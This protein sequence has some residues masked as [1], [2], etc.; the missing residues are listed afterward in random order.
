MLNLL[1]S[2]KWSLNQAL[3]ALSDN[4]TFE[5]NELLS[6]DTSYPVGAVTVISVVKLLPDMVKDCAVPRTSST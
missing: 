1:T 6:V 5:L 4:T 3:P 2:H